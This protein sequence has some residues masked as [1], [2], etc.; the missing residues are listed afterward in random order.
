MAPYISELIEA[1]MDELGMS[2][3][4][5]AKRIGIH[6]ET[7]GIWLKNGTFDIGFL[8]RISIA[9]ERNFFEALARELEAEKPA[10]RV[11]REPEVAYGPPRQQI[12]PVRVEIDLLDADQ[13]ALA[14]DFADKL[15]RVQERKLK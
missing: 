7:L 12:T 3:T 1:R 9:L 14:L 11:V 6:R 13:Q 15:R 10:L 8:K 2:V 5:L 4:T